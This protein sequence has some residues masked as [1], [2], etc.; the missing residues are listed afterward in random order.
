MRRKAVID[1][2]YRYE[3]R[4]EWGDDPREIAWIMLNPSTA[5]HAVDD[6]TMR[7][8]IDFS[9]RF[10]FER[11]R[12]VNLFALRS[13]NPKDLRSPNPN[14]V[15]P[16][17]SRYIVCAVEDCDTLVV[18]WGANRLARERSPMLVDFC[19]EQ[20]RELYCLGTTKDGSPRHPGRLS[21]STR[22]VR[23]QPPK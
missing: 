15:G 14:P 22:L 8:V 10:G 18:A 4:R 23:W 13:P 17:N 5:D 6:P 11:L 21:A 9:K 16:N 7:R 19:K 20:G 3:L 2:P 1:D 12:V